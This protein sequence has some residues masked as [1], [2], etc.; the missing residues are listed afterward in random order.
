[1]K[2]LFLLSAIVCVVLLP[3]CE[4]EVLDLAPVDKFS[5]LTAFDTPE[6]CEL[7]VVGAYDAA[8]C[9]RYNG[10]YSRG[11]PFGASSILQGEMRGEDMNL[12]A[13]FY[14]I[15]YSATYNTSTSNNQYYWET[16]FECINRVNTVI[17]GIE[18]ATSEGVLSQEEGDAY[19]GE[20]LFLR[21]L[22]YHGLTVH[23]TLPVNVPGN[24]DYGLPLYI[25]AINTPDEIKSA[26]QVGRSTVSE[27]YAQILKDLDE[28]EGLFGSDGLH[29]VNGITRVSK[30]SV[31][32]LKTRVYLHQR[33]WEKVIEEAGKL[34]PGE[35]P[36]VSPVG[37]YQLAATPDIPFT[38]YLN[39]TESIFSIE[40]SSDDEGS[41][42]GAMAAMMSAREGGR[43]IVTSSPTVYNSPYWLE[44]DKRRGLL[45]YSESDQYYFCDK[46]KEALTRA[47][48]APII[49]YAEVLLNYAEAALRTGDKALSLELLNAVRNRSL[50][51]PGTQAYTGSS[52]STDQEW[53]DAI[54]WERRIEFHG[55]GRRWEDIHRLA[56]DDLSPSGGIPAKIEY[57]NAKN[58]GAFGVGAPLQ[59]EWFTSSR[60]FIP[61]TDKRFLWPIPVDDIVRNPTLATQQNAGW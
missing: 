25:T 29:D 7:S 23:F 4:G 59:E 39:N 11:Y 44:D 54:L 14:D 48:Y 50:S 28:A 33:N 42:N 16:S 5:E 41:V 51:D 18:T 6:H 60:A 24:N 58:K 27:T 26:L 37:G 38:S 2:Y 13:I 53:L 10:S 43:A 46:Y 31:I 57:K 19:K 55:E 20:L 56:N 12:T 52:F 1:M 32:A 3:G 45:Y 40:N 35:A 15:T 22:T 21:A 34:A 47:D 49:R 9:G 8:Q 36:F 30:G 61:Y 17:R